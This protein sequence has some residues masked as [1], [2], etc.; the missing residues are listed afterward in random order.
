MIY[1]IARN[2]VNSITRTFL[3]ENRSDFWL[4]PRGWYIIIV[5]EMSI[6]VEVYV[7]YAVFWY[8]CIVVDVEARW[9]CCARE[10]KEKVKE[11]KQA[12][13]NEIEKSQNPSEYWKTVQRETSTTTKKK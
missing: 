7:Y 9:L 10:E 11:K 1:L 5:E 8:R 3:I 13:Y 4:F 2:K 12:R 6:T